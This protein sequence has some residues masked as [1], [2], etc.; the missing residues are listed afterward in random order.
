[1]KNKRA[2]EIY[3][4]TRELEVTRREGSEQACSSSLARG[5]EFCSLVYLLRISRVSEYFAR[6][7]LAG[8]REYLQSKWALR[9]FEG[10]L[11]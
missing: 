3:A 8:I 11:F 9:L 1:M 2:G 4:R 10:F 7:S 6:S 5:R